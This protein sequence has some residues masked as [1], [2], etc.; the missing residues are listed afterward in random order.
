MRGAVLGQFYLEL[1]KPDDRVLGLRDFF[2][3]VGLASVGV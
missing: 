3:P 2:L 1:I